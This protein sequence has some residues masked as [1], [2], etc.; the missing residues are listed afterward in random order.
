[1]AQVSSCSFW[2]LLR[3]SFLVAKRPKTQQKE[4]QAKK[5]GEKNGNKNANANFEVSCNTQV[6]SYLVSNCLFFGAAANARYFLIPTC[7]FCLLS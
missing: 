5:S 7:V 2:W 6:V 4:N 1:V 3:K